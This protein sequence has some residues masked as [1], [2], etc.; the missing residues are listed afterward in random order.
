MIKT[1]LPIKYSIL[2]IVFCSGI[3]SSCR[4]SEQS[5]TEENNT[6]FNVVVNLVSAE[7]QPETFRKTT[8]SDQK[9]ISDNGVQKFTVPLDETTDITATLSPKVEI[10]KNPAT[11]RAVTELENDIRY[12]VAVYDSSGN[13]VDEKTFTYKQD[14]TGFQLDG[15]QNYTFVA[16]SVNST[17]TVPTV[18]NNPRTLATD[19]LNNVNGDLMYFKT[20]MTV[21]N[22]RTNYLDI[23]LKHLYSQITTKLDARQV[24]AISLVENATI[25][26][27]N[28]SANLSL[29]TGSLTYNASPGAVTPV[30]NFQ[31]LNTEVVTSAPTLLISNTTETARL[32]IGRIIVGG[33]PRDNYRLNDL[34]ITPGVQ[35]NLNLRLGPCRENVNPSVRFSI[36]DGSP[37]TYDVPATD[38]GYVID[39]LTMTKS[40][41]LD[42]NGTRIAREEIY[43][44]TQIYG[45]NSQNVRFTDGTAWGRNGIPQIYDM[46]GDIGR[47]LI[48]VVISKDGD[49]S[50]FGSKTSGG[51]LYPIEA[52]N[53]NRFNTVPLNRTGNNTLRASQFN[54]SLTYMSGTITGQRTIPCAP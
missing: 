1:I 17:S 19:R 21:S 32:N 26:P 42:I 44:D 10:K 27:T 39:I 53:N 11:T 40:F 50:M 12:K 35:Y 41:M 51:D 16:Y 34:K 43:F 28:N 23:V 18:S 7:N 13:F 45:P 3:L 9:N 46:V 52:I 31:T 15:N 54:I 4:S 33:I 24:G 36:R 48:R 47:P 49:V 20:N 38:F 22:S 37:R 14:D 29:G 6:P 5:I 8:S 30:T 25:G 2:F